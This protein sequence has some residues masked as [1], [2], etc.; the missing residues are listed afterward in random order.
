MNSHS[1]RTKDRSRE[2]R[3]VEKEKK[4][5]VD[6]DEEDGLHPM[7]L[8]ELFYYE[9]MIRKVELLQNIRR[10]ITMYVDNREE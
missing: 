5:S 6:E 9:D 7:C 4:N 1:V 10:V 2:L 8:E 3:C